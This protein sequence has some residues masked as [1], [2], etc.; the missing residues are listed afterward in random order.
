MRDY[1]ASKGEATP[2]DAKFDHPELCEIQEG[3][4]AIAEINQLRIEV[5]RLERKVEHQ[6][7]YIDDYLSVRKKVYD[8]LALDRSRR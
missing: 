6:R 3:Q 5:E 7:R 2:R 1:W 8:D 4:D